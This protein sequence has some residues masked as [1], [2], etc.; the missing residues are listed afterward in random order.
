MEPFSRKR[1]GPTGS[2]RVFGEGRLI[3]ADKIRNPQCSGT[4]EYVISFTLGRAKKR[5]MCEERR[6]PGTVIFAGL[7]LGAASH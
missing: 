6:D 1:K 2:F 4:P 5:R 3:V 7:N